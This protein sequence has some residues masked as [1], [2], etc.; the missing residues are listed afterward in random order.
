MPLK[1]ADDAW[2]LDKKVPVAIIVVLIGQFLLGLWFIAKLD[3]KVEEQAARLAKTEAQV[4][5]IDR[6]AREFGNRIVRIEEKTS[7]M[8]TILQRV[9]RLIDR[10]PPNETP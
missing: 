9:E 5:V 10:R 4:S 8:L 3:S 7:S 6:E 2:H 1:P